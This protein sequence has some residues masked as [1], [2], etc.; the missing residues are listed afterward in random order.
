MRAG[1]ISWGIILVF[2]GVIFLLENY[3]VI[4]FSWSYVWK[5]WPV[6]FIITGLNIIFSRSEAKAGQWLVILT[7]VFA[8]GL[9]TYVNLNAPKNADRNWE[10]RF[11]HG[12]EQNGE[13]SGEEH[14][15]SFY[16]ETY[17]SKFKTATLNISG[18]ASKFKI[19]NGDNN[20][21]ESAT[22]KNQNRYY[23]RRTDTDST[24]VLNFKSKDENNSFNF[25]D[26]D[27]SKVEMKIHPMPIWDINLN[28]GAGK[29][30]FDLSKNRVK[31]INIKGGAAEFQVKLGSLYNDVNLSAE[32]GIAKVSILIPAASGC[33]INT[34]TGLSA[35]DFPGFTKTEDGIYTS[36]NYNSTTNKIMINLKGGLSDFEVKRY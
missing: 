19:T 11:D 27:V 1:K 4:D 14:T 28:M 29:A 21:F 30:D 32:T 25:D 15:Q 34:K 35:K 6:I 36:P 20:L 10:F 18:G 7:T 33:K 26:T 31:Q 17:D 12:N 23:L 9:L 8:L 3:D 5:F 13:W 16:K 24:V 22:Q 2:V